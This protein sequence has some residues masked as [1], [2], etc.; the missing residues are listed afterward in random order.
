MLRREQTRSVIG[1]ITCP[2]VKLGVLICLGVALL[3]GRPGAAEEC[4]SPVGQLAS[5]EG[6]V[7][8]QSGGDPG[9]RV[10][11]PGATLCKDDTLR[12]GKLSRAAVALINDEVLRL[13][14]GTTLRLADV[15]V[16]ASQPSILDLA[17]G[18]VQSFSRSPRRV[19]VNTS[20][21]TLAIR[22]TEFAIRADG[23]QSVLTVFEGEVLGQQCPGRVGRSGGALRRRPRRP[24]AAALS[25][26]APA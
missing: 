3:P 23:Q 25:R 2:V 16:E 10:A 26:G 19:N 21:M 4:N 9:W 20:Y 18:A 8:V 14:E 15:P 11:E 12:T 7:E 5:A 6:S 1:S 13:D 17:F 22:G 24:G